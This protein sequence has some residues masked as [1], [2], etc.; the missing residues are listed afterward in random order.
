MVLIRLGPPTQ[1]ILRNLMEYE[2]RFRELYETLP[3]NYTRNQ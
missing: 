2:Q 1:I 3:Q